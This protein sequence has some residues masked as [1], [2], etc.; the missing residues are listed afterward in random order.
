VDDSG[1]GSCSGL[2][3]FNLTYQVVSLTGHSNMCRLAARLRTIGQV[4]AGVGSRPVAGGGRAGCGDCSRRGGAG[5]PTSA[6][7]RGVKGPGAGVTRLHPP[8][9]GTMAPSGASL[10]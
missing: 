8:H 3:A 6:W 1:V 5:L 9:A 4:A 10:R 7:G 2:R